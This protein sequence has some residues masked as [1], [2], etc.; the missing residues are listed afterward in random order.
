M[1][2]RLLEIEPNELFG[3]PAILTS[4]SGRE[5]ISRPFEFSLSIASPKE[6]IRPE[7]VIGQKLAVRIDRDEAEF[8]GK[9]GTSPPDL[10][11]EDQ[12]PAHALAKCRVK[13]IL[14]VTART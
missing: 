14:A 9:T 7:D 8:A 13:H 12:R 1:T 3:E 4:L 11:A 2:K 10:A 6:N 5:E